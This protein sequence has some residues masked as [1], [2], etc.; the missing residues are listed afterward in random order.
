MT[1][2]ETNIKDCFIIE[3]QVFSDNRGY[4]FESFNQELFNQKTGLK[5]EFVQD[6]ESFSSKGVLRGLH[7]QTGNYAQAKLVRVIKGRV[8]DIAVDVRPNSKTFGAHIAIELS[9]QNKKQ[10]FIPRGFAHGFLTLEENTIF[11]YKCDNYYNKSAEAGI[12]YND[13]TLNINWQLPEKDLIL[14]EKD[15]ALPTFNAVQNAL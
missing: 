12:I 4:F 15:K 14:S 6:N 7:L 11:S 1:I 8:L 9:A 3:P 2:K 13:A 5:I 10:L